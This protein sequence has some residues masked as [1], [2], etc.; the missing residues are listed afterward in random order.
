[1][2]HIWAPQCQIQLRGG[3]ESNHRDW[4][5]PQPA[6][7]HGIELSDPVSGGLGRVQQHGDLAIR[8]GRRGLGETGR[9]QASFAGH[10]QRI[11]RGRLKQSLGAAQ[12]VGGKTNLTLKTPRA[13]ALRLIASPS[14]SWVAVT[15]T[16]RP[17]SLRLRS[18]TASPFGPTT[19]RIKSATGTHRARRHTQPFAFA[20]VRSGI[21]LAVG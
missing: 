8:Q 19:K 21:E 13:N 15:Q 3:Q 2:Y 5:A 1:M 10:R 14:A 6:A 4:V 16:P 11:E 12:E 20:V 9:D 17:G 18:G 7:E